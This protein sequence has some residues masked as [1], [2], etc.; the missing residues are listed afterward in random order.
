MKMKTK[1]AKTSYGRVM[2]HL[3]CFVRD[4]HLRWHWAGIARE[5]A[6]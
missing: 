6:R 4:G 2:L 1:L 5:I 3:L